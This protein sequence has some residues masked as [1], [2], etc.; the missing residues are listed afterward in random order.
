[1]NEHPPPLQHD[2][3]NPTLRVMLLPRDTNAHGTIFGGV[4]LSHLDMAGMIEARKHTHHRIVTVAMHEVEFLAPVFVGD[5][6][7]F[8]SRTERIGRTSI[9]VKVEVEAERADGSGYAKVTEAD[10]VYVAVDGN[11]RPIP[12]SEG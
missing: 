5:V 9:T 2:R 10:V 4:I 7:S 8:Y 11:G 12:V 6:V 1:M 3:A